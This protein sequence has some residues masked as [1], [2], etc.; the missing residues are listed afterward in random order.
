MRALLAAGVPAQC[1][2][3][4]GHSPLHRACFRGHNGIARALIEADGECV[5]AASLLCNTPLHAAVFAGNE[6]LVTLLLDSE[7]D[8][9]V[10]NV[11]GNLPIHRA[12]AENSCPIVV[13]LLGACRCACG[14][15]CS[16]AAAG[17]GG[18]AP[19]HMMALLHCGDLQIVDRLLEHAAVAGNVST[20]RPAM[21]LAVNRHGKTPLDLAIF[22]GNTRLAHRLQLIEDSSQVLASRA[23]PSGAPV[24]G[25]TPSAS[26]SYDGGSV[27]A[28]PLVGESQR[29]GASTLSD[30]VRHAKQAVEVQ[31]KA[32]GTS[33][34]SCASGSETHADATAARADT[35]ACKSD[36]NANTA[37]QCCATTTASGSAAAHTPAPLSATHTLV[38]LSATHT[39]V[40]LSA[41]TA[42]SIDVFSAAIHA[43]QAPTFQAAAAAFRREHACTLTELAGQAPPLSPQL[44]SS[45]PPPVSPVDSPPADSLHHSYAMWLGEQLE[46]ALGGLGVTWD[47]LTRACAR[48]VRGGRCG[49]ERLRWL[50]Y[51]AAVDD[52]YCFVELMIESSR[53]D[54]SR[55]E[56]PGAAAVDGETSAEAHTGAN[57]EEGVRQEGKAP[58]VVAGG[59]TASA[60]AAIANAASPNAPPP[61]PALASASLAAEAVAAASAAGTIVGTMVGTMASAAGVSAAAAR[62][63]AKCHASR[64]V[65]T[66]P[67]KLAATVAPPASSMAHGPGESMGYSTFSLER[68]WRDALGSGMGDEGLRTADV[69]GMG[70][71]G[72]TAFG[73]SLLSNAPRTMRKR[74]CLAGLPLPAS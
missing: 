66:A 35:A 36:G 20:A 39:L 18:N 7:A 63:R 73:S 53:A 1:A 38:P 13:S 40:P 46:V 3:G 34:A 52:Y 5:H 15:A 64:P 49:G 70:G 61:R 21:Q 74:R 9:A 30:K 12:V 60:D 31:W 24:G 65:S 14:A 8:A 56:S 25:S 19:L 4:N 57:S 62:A 29:P 48:A 44:P 10:A 33:G 11:A 67:S 50:R 54:P 22:Q 43:I 58:D 26:S 28:A 32:G 6:S 42:G 45:M 16:A 69:M 27:S 68:K 71:T 37:T 2:D 23:T 47:G 41:A 17:A 51:L 55:A 59:F 72:G